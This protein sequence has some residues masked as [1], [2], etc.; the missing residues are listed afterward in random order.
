MISI[1]PHRLQAIAGNAATN[2][3]RGWMELVNRVISSTNTMDQAVDL[4]TTGN[5]FINATGNITV[6]LRANALEDEWVTVRH[7]V[8]SGN[9]TITDGLGFVILTVRETVVTF[10]F[11][12]NEGWIIGA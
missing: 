7:D 4:T 8:A 5:Q 10:R 12:P 9:V 3:M 6:T 11:K 1:L 2:V